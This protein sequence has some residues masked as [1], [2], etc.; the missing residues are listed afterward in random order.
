[1]PFALH[2]PTVVLSCGL[3]PCPV[4][5]GAPEPEALHRERHAGLGYLRRGQG[6]GDPPGPLQEGTYG[7]SSFSSWTRSSVYGMKATHT[8]MKQTGMEYSVCLCGHPTQT[9]EV[10]QSSEVTF[11]FYGTGALARQC[12]EPHVHRG[13]L[14]LR[15]ALPR[16]LPGPRLH[17]T[18]LLP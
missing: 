15:H 8:I 3:C 7:F 12:Q 17:P 5:T 14:P 6:R 18:C 10:S 2:K 13:Q 16:H 11:F 4:L 1:M 9:L